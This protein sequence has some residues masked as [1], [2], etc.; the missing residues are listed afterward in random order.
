MKKLLLPILL[1][2]AGFSACAQQNAFDRFYDKMKSQDSVSVELSI[3][4]SLWLSAAFSEKGDDTWKN[5]ISTIRLLILDGKKTRT[6]TGEFD[7][8]CR[9]LQK[10]KFDALVDIHQGKERMQLLEKDLDGSM[11]HLILLMHGKDDGTIFAELKGRFTQAD[12]AHM[13]RSMRDGQ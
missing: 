8:V 5:K 1:A 13:E 2:M 10:D 12:L 7:E 6:S 9:D 4:P 3:S 11:K